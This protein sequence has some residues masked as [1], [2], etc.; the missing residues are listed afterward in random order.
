VLGESNGM[1]NTSFRKA[2]GGISWPLERVCGKINP[3]K[4][5][6]AS[7]LLKQPLA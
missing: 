5:G 2:K 6:F 4:Y 3:S 7:A 1:A